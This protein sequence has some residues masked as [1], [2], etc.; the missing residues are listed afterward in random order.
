MSD[1]GVYSGLTLNDPHLPAVENS[2]GVRGYQLENLFWFQSG[3]FHVLLH[4]VSYLATDIRMST[5]S[6]EYSLIDA[7]L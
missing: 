5:H 7:M 6:R 3:K 4:N 2:A 1:S